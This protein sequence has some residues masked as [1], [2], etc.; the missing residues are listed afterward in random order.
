MGDAAPLLSENGGEGEERRPKRRKPGIVYLSSIPPNMNV[1]KI[2]QYFSAY[3]E[4]GRV[5]LQA[6]EKDDKSKGGKGKK[7]KKSLHFTEGWLEFKSKRKAKQVHVCLNNQ[8]VGGKRKNHFYDM[9][10][11]IK[12]LPRFK[13]AYLKQ[14]LEYEREMTRQRMGAEIS[15]VRKET[16]HFLKLS[17]ISKKKKKRKNQETGKEGKEGEVSDA[18]KTENKDN[19][20]VFKQKETEE[21]KL[22]KKEER[23]RKNELFKKRIA[24]KKKKKQKKKT[25]KPEDFL[26]SVFVGAT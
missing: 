4:L 16:D 17:E 22:S 25:D 5:F 11:N 6:V 3:G 21:E 12:Y 9:L 20:F 26:G 23:K 1:A 19:L 15:Q 18:T 7:F 10:W 13:W 8:P 14:R 2:R 24:Q